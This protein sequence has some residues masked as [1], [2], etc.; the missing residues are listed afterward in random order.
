MDFC[1][2]HKLKFLPRLMLRKEMPEIMD[3]LPEIDGG[4]PIS[5]LYRG[6]SDQFH[7][8]NQIEFKKGLSW[9]KFQGC[10]ENYNG[11][12]PPNQTA[13][14]VTVGSTLSGVTAVLL[15]IDGDNQQ[16]KHAP[17]ITKGAVSITE[18]DRMSGSIWFW[19][20]SWLCCTPRRMRLYPKW[21]SRSRQKIIVENS[22]NF[23]GN[24]RRLIKRRLFGGKPKVPTQ[25]SLWMTVLGIK[26]FPIS[27]WK[28]NRLWR[29][30][31]TNT[32]SRWRR[33]K[34]QWRWRWCGIHE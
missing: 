7:P 8:N 19:R 17:P 5:C 31:T 24:E 13:T 2:P 33:Y 1:E 28:R 27:L 11:A 9:N 20:R 6:G 25:N 29:R 15:S 30:W 32:W 16:P 22:V 34:W 3:E 4:N 23:W 10:F 18:C 14:G 12:I 21:L 26:L